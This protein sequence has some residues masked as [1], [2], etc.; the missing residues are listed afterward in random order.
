MVSANGEAWYTLNKCGAAVAEGL[1]GLQWELAG[2]RGLE[3]RHRMLE[4][5]RCEPL[6]AGAWQ[7]VPVHVG[8]FVF[9]D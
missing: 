9:L 7:E 5:K 3:A 2:Q 4:R 1:C 6:T 8:L